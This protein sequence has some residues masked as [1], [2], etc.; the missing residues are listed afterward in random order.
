MSH[1]FARLSTPKGLLNPF[2]GLSEL[3]DVLKKAEMRRYKD[4]CCEFFCNLEDELKKAWKFAKNTITEQTVKAPCLQNFHPHKAFVEKKKCVLNHDY[5]G[6]SLP[7]NIL[8]NLY[9]LIIYTNTRKL[10]LV[11]NYYLNPEE[12][13]DPARRRRETIEAEAIKFRAYI[14]E[15]RQFANIQM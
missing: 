5:A 10:V 6:G 3:N 12:N 11:M 15:A 7:E 2:P 8:E 13:E 9:P 1:N 14:K 4:D